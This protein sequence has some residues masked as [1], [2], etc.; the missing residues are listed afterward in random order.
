MEGD[1]ELKLIRDFCVRL[2]LLTAL[3]IPFVV[4]V[5]LRCIY[6]SLIH[7]KTDAIGPREWQRI[8]KT[9]PFYKL[10]QTLGFNRDRIPWG[11][12]ARCGRVT[13]Y[14]DEADLF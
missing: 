5:L 2:V 12:C 7:G 4:W 14:R 1:M 3:I 8:V 11:A 10:E 6:C 13:L 9:S